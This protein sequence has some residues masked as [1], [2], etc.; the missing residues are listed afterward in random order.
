MSAAAAAG[1]EPEP[2]AAGAEVERMPIRY[3]RNSNTAHP[4]GDPSFAVQQCMPG[5]VPQAECD[6]FLM[7]D[8]FG[9]TP[10]KGA[11]GNDTDAGFDVPWHPHHGMDILSYMV[12]GMGRHA[13]SMGNRETFRSPGFQWMSV[14]SGIEHA[15]GGGTPKGQRTHGF[16][17]WLRMPKTKMK[18]DPRYG[19]VETDAI[20]TVQL[21]K[22]LVRVIGGVCRGVVGPAEFAV[23]VQILDVELQAGGE[24][25]YECPAEMD[26]VMFYSFKGAGTLNGDTPMRAQQVCRFDTTT[27]TKTATIQAGTD[28]FRLMVF[29]GKM[30]KE[31]LIWHGP[32]VC[33][34]K[35]QLTG[36]FEQY[37]G[38]NFPPVRVPWDYKNAKATPPD[39]RAK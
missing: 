9:P 35:K 15:E 2:Q 28:G 20:P 1:P 19:T 17:I 29:T 30:T 16:Q 38:G 24:F 14:G 26:N 11:H 37:Q 10:S 21:D 32:F 25:E 13:D 6:P 8:E 34:S 39:K 36:C 33:A 5:V 31:S 27:G 22:G 12:E 7:C 23:Q 18:D 3:V 4:T